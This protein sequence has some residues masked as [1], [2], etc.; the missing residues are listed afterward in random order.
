MI[1]LI[2]RKV[3]VFENKKKIKRQK[4][5]GREETK[6][7]KQGKQFQQVKQAQGKAQHFI[8]Y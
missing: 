3:P 1:F 4:Q 6:K 2:D 7:S 8:T 5:I